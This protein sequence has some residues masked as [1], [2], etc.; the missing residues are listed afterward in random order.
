MRRGPRLLVHLCATAALAL[1][2]LSP[3]ASAQQAVPSGD[4]AGR[5]WLT[6]GGNFFNQRY[7]S[8]NQI[9]T[10]NV[11]QLKGAW[12][13]HTG[14]FSDATSFESSP[15]VSGGV[16]YLT[17]PQSQVYALDAKTGSELW[18]YVPDY[19][20]T[21]IAGVTGT[22]ALPLCCGQVNRGV[23]L[24]D[25]RVYVAQLDDKLTALDARSGNVLWSVQ[26]DDPRAG[27]SQ[28]MA[29]LFYEGLV[30]VGVSGAEYEIRGHVTAYDAAS[31][32]Q[33]W[34]FYTIPAPGE[35][36]ADT[37][38]QDS[39]IWQYGGGSM[40]QTPAL[41]PDLGM[42]YIAVGN[43]SPDLDGT[44]RAGN[45]LFTESIVALDARTG[46]RKWHF[47]E[48]HHDIWDYDTVS[49]AV[50]FNTTMNGQAVKGIGQAGKTGWLYLLDRTNGQPL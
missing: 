19:S 35:F 32:R 31:G 47:Q 4:A 33:V 21:A 13:F 50:L 20:G 39:N 10:G 28:T 6:Y 16:M 3:N 14:A 27:Y 46:Q 37:W 5:E 25:G 34:R 11:A 18:K 2:L 43:P 12:T 1:T 29:P 44:V 26:D 7:S 42:L 22:A 8:L 49:P 41:D 9:T 23:A 24:G 15:I 38:P 36:G 45:N 48:V 17:G 40:W 30:I